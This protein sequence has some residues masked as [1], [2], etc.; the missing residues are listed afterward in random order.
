MQIL[1]RGQLP[2]CVYEGFKELDEKNYLVGYRDAAA[3]EATH[4]L[5][6][7]DCFTALHRAAKLKLIQLSNFDLKEYEHWEQVENGDLNW[8]IPGKVLAFCSP[9]DN[10]KT[11]NLEDD[12][13][14]YYSH[15]PGTVVA[16]LPA[17]S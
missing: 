12:G 5:K 8:L 6:L 17:I 7:L 3:G 15:T 1:E 16:Y 13:G 9:V 2:Q 4:R 14:D 10:T 11:K